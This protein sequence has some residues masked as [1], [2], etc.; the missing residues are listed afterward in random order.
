MQNFFL[1]KIS[2]PMRRHF[3]AQPADVLARTPRG[4]ARIAGGGYAVRHTAGRGA[5]APAT[6]EPESCER[7]RRE[8]APLRAGVA[9]F[10][11][12]EIEGNRDA[13]LRAA[14]RRHRMKEMRGKDRR[15]ARR[16]LKLARRPTG[17]V[18]FR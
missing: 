15:D 12:A 9:I 2:Q 10:D 3:H 14:R 18:I 13:R 5:G 8:A 17:S 7:I 4:V 1:H 16:R 6:L 11:R